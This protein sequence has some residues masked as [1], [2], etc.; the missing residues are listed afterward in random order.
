VKHVVLQVN[1][2]LG[3]PRRHGAPDKRIQSIAEQVNAGLRRM[4]FQLCLERLAQAG[5]DAI[6]NRA[7]GYAV[8]IVWQPGASVYWDWR[9]LSEICNSTV[10]RPSATSLLVALAP[11]VD[12]W[13]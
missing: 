1:T 8:F 7:R 5:V 4:L 12:L 9:V 13:R 3:Q 2:A 11:V 6:V 10:K